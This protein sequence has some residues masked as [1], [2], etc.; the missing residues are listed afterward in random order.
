[1]A[2]FE[3]DLDRAFVSVGRSRHLGVMGIAASRFH[4]GNRDARV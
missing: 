2:P 3:P 4:V 1:M